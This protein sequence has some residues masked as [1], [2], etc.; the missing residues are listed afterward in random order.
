MSKGKE[1]R[2]V[3]GVRVAQAFVEVNYLECGDLKGGVYLGV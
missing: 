3:R 2:G 1:F